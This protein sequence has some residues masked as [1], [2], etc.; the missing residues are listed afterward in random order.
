MLSF[1]SRFKHGQSCQ[2]SQMQRRAV[3]AKFFAN[4]KFL[5]KVFHWNRRMACLGD[6][7]FLCFF[8]LCLKFWKLRFDYF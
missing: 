6:D 7:E 5:Q 3:D 8:C 1:G 2:H 4:V